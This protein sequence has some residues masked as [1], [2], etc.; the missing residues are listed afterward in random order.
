MDDDHGAQ[1]NKWKDHHIDLIRVPYFHQLSF[2]PKRT[3]YL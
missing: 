3:A 1:E 2:H